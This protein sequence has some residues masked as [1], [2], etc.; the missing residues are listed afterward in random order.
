MSQ[1]SSRV[2][3]WNYL[4]LLSGYGFPSRMLCMPPQP[5]RRTCVWPFAVA[6]EPGRGGGG[7]A[8]A[9]TSVDTGG[10][11]PPNDAIHD[12]LQIDAANSYVY[13]KLLA[14]KLLTQV[15]RC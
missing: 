12:R 9:L 7:G 3:L 6:A 2:A 1:R 4:Q 15:I 10:I 5:P 13:P 14:Y 8:F 11:A